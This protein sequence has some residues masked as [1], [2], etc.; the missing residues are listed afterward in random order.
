MPILKVRDDNGQIHEISAL[1]GEKAKCDLEY[2]PESENAQSGKAVAEAL[3][4]ALMTEDITVGKAAPNENTT[5]KFYFQ[6][7]E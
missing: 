4:K 2:N 5:G 6:Y 3:Q 7:V 1:R